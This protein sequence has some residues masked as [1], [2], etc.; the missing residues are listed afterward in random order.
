MSTESKL[1]E[2]LRR[3]TAE[4]YE[5]RQRL[6][7]REDADPIVIVGMG[8]RYPGEV[9]TP[10]QLWDLLDAGRDAIT[11]FPD[12]RGWD[13]DRLYHPDPDH[14]GTSYTR[15]GGFLAD[16]AG[17]DAAFFAMSPREAL[18]TDPQQRLFLETSWEALERA[19]IAPG[20]LG[21]S[22]TGVFCGLMYHDY[23]GSSGAGSVTSGRVAYAL[24]LEGPALTVDTACSSSLVT[25]H[26]AAHA[27]RTGECSLAL[28]GG[29]TVLA[30][31]DTFVEFS[32]QRGLAPDGR[33]KSFAA[34]AD[35]TGWSEGAGV[36]V[37]ER[38]SDARRNGHPVLATVR[39]SAVNSDGASNGLTAPNGPAQ[40][41]VIRD[42]LLD[43]GLTP[44]DVDA[45][46]AHG[47]GTTL[48]DPI[49]AQALL[50]TYG[51]GRAEDRPL[52]LGSIK[53]NL[54]HSQAAAG[55]AGIMKL[56]LAMRHGVLPR[57]LHVDEPSP[58]VDWSGGT[59]RLLTESRPWPETAA[60][61]RAAVS[62]FGVSG[63][64]AHVIL[65][66]PPAAEEPPVPEHDGRVLPLVLSG[67]TAT[68][69]REQAGR[70]RDLLA[71]QDAPALA[72]T[73]YSLA[74]TRTA[75]ERRAVVPA[76]DRAEALRG[77]TEL[78]EATPSAEVVEGAGDAA[79]DPGK[80]VFVFPGQGSQWAGMAVDL[81]ETSPV[82]RQRMA[83][84]EAALKP[85][86]DWPVTGV[87]RG[88]PGAPAMDTAEVVQPVLFAVLVSLAAVW[89]SA[90]VR[91]DAVLGHSQG[92]IAAA[93]VAGA[94]SLD[95]A[96]RVVALRSRALSAL[97]GRGGLASV[98]LSP[99]RVADRIARWSGRLSVA[100]VNAPDSVV[101]AGAPE[102]LEELLAECEAEEI[103]ARRIDVDYASHSPQV[104]DIH[105]ELL[106]VLA[107]I[108]PRPAEIPLYSTV[109]EGDD[110]LGWLDTS[111][112]D[113]EYWYRNLR[114][115]VGFAPAVTA[116]LGQGH[117]TFVEVSPHP[118][119]TSAV[120]ETADAAE[121]DAVV[122]GTLRRDEDGPRRFLLSLGEL[123]V[124][125]V[126]V[127]WTSAFPDTGTVDLPTYP[128]Q[129]ER[130]WATA[131]TGGDAAGSLGLTAADH[132]LLGAVVG[133][134]ADGGLLLTGRLS[135]R[136]HPWL[137][138]HAV[139]DQVLLP[140]TAFAELALRA[141]DEVGCD[142]LAEL[143]LQEPL[144]LPGRAELLLQVSVAAPG[145]DGKRELGVY[146]RPA[147]GDAEWSR[148]ATG[149]LAAGG[150]A[151]P[152]R[153]EQW[154]PAGATP[155]EVAEVYDRMAGA[156]LHYGPAFRGLRRLWRGEGE[157]FAEVELTGDTDPAGFGLHP[158]LL[159]AALHPLGLG[160]LHGGEA[161][162]EVEVGGA[163][164]PFAFGGLRLHAVGATALRARLTAA[165][166]NTVRV[167]LTDTGG[168]PVALVES[169][170]VRPFDPGAAT[171]VATG[172]AG[173]LYRL[174]WPELPAPETARG[175]HWALLGPD[176]LNLAGA[177]EAAGI[178]LDRHPDL[179]S[180]TGTP[181]TVLVSLPA[182]EQPGAAATRAAAHRAL[183]LVRDWLAESQAEPTAQ[184]FAD[185][186]LV[187]LTSGAVDTGAGI[188]D[189]A[190]A[191]AWGLL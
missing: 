125:G 81:L 163:W 33:C 135:T 44:G 148:H 96:A 11:E 9:A 103:R 18:G 140:G 46:E 1:R 104:A 124:H 17:F 66:Q 190:G 172:P 47:T 99:P 13:L 86:L 87:L 32:R 129:R 166:P 149:L 64:N 59:V 119:L 16:P 176:P 109:A 94:L 54:G 61:R 35:G 157:L 73:G 161:E 50:A 62:S 15:H 185:A 179:A 155:V 4:L 89:A 55:A 182:P 162:A 150:P 165:G 65:E 26:L 12:D 97:A 153:L 85:F 191:A 158:A 116:L 145:E 68:A 173:T 78:A 27:L 127:D 159:D 175:G 101:V 143:T 111:T 5:T 2:Y 60:P 36:L 152:A 8:C 133:T 92:E 114:E 71:G 74:T 98:A 170:A 164:L 131:A 76:A 14:P 58:H 147:D 7:A 156:G 186:R 77:L 83:E 120:Q 128:F 28:A 146:S 75:F 69:L 20:S 171:A 84:C 30:R 79:T 187:L 132:P 168:E 100:A 37:L 53:S 118:V 3:V 19:R 134:A 130:Y 102:A 154:P 122:A 178:R 43:A 188:A 126:A 48:G 139:G 93:C 117:G 63:T 177:A 45:V 180:V 52:W 137:A 10:E 142:Q 138:E 88:E 160:T 25:V 184:R 21:G 136:T 38:L 183:E 151:A 82:F 70:V 29:V 181:D 90:G 40:Q 56:V 113:A 31:P 107:P 106:E 24:G 57:T 49:E 67:R 42:A 72:G 123:H 91:P 22:R 115:T 110:P 6:R 141:G 39:G 95:D 105:A 108:T 189:P 80:L 144:V 121:A 112:M 41:R 167:E 23:P 51:G 169:L 174:D 34:S